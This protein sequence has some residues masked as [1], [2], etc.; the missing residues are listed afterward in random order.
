MY[1]SLLNKNDAN[2]TLYI[3]NCGINS[4]N[5]E[6]IKENILKYIEHYAESLTEY[7]KLQNSSL[8]KLLTVFQLKIY[9]H[10]KPLV[11]FT[12]LSEAQEKEKY[13]DLLNRE[14]KI[15]WKK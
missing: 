10:E 7:E 14:K 5:K 12:Y 2:N 3:C 13:Y 15:K 6:E 4:K 1:Y 11:R 9:G 8:G